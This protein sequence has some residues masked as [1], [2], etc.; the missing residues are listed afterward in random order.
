MRL[1]RFF[2]LAVGL[3]VA[4]ATADAFAIGQATGRVTG[5]V[6]EGQS[7]APIPGAVVTVSGGSGV[8]MVVQTNE[9]GTFEAT[10][11][12]P[13]TYDLVVTYEG[14]KP[15]KRRVVVNP[16]AATPVTIVWSAEA[17]Q[18]ETT[19]VEEERRL[20][21][22][23]SPQTGQIYARERTDQLPVSRAYQAISAQVP[24]ATTS[25]GNPSVKGGRLNNNRLL[26]NGLDIT[27]PVTNQATASFQMDA[28][29]SVQLTT[30]GFEAKYN[31]LGAITTVQ[32]RRGTNNFHGSAAAYWAPSELVDYDTYGSQIYDGSKPFD[33]SAIKPK[34]GRYELNVNAQGPILKDRLFFNAGI[35]YE[36]SSSVQP[37]GPP[38]NAQAPS[39]VFESI[40]I[41]GGVTFVPTPAHRIH[42]ESFFDPTHADY[43]GNTGA[44]ANST[45]PYSQTGRFAGGRR[46]TL[47]WAWQAN[48]HVATKVMIG[49]NES[50]IE[51][52]PQGLRG[53]DSSDLTNGVPYDWF[54]SNHQNQDD[55]TSWFNAGSHNVITRRR[56]QLDAA[57]TATGELGGRHEA[58]FGLQ[59][60]FTEQRSQLSYPGGT[61]GPNDTT[62]YGVFYTDR[63]GGPLDTRLCDL[64]PQL[65]P[66]ALSGNYTGTGCFRRTYSRSFAGHSSGNQF[67]TYIQDR[68]K[69]RRWLTVLPGVRWD[70]GTVR[71]T[72]SAVAVTAHGFGPRL[73]VIADVTNDQKTIA[74]VSYGRMT[75]MPTLSGV[76]SYDQARRQV[77][78]V[79]QY[80]Q[81][82]R[83]F[84]FAQTTGGSAGTRLN[85]D[86]TPA[87]ADEILVSGR[88]ELTNGVLI[89]ADY[90]YRY[91]RNQYETAEVNAIMDPTG[92]RT[93]GW[94][95]GIPQRMTLYGFNPA[96]TARYSGLDLILETR[97]PI[98][99][100]QGSY[101]LSQSMGNAGSGAF[102][103]PRFA[104]FY[105]SFQN[106]DTRHAIKTSTTFHPFPGFTIGLILNWRSGSALIKSYSANE[107]GYSVRRAPTG[108]E[109]GSYPNTGTANPGQ[110]GTYSDLRSWSTFRTP[111]LFT[112]NVMVSY[113][114]NT[115]IK[116]HVIVNLQINNL[117]A[118]ETATGINT[119]EGAPT[120][121][122]FGLAST[123]NGFRSFTLGARY[124]F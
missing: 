51:T 39:T 9:E 94:V 29:D 108:F 18:E 41:L 72:D 2:A 112:T 110:L 121:T 120:S 69:P 78:V 81:R 44:S 31:A 22:P 14:L 50:T 101:T 57:V 63:G 54:R 11:I 30:G 43:D 47:E 16:D 124:E 118:L 74:Q 5:T 38:R 60:M 79:E 80:D 20:T 1:S 105:Q 76:V 85:F 119:S 115:L 42:V 61:S 68:Y 71:A 102:D 92:T 87:S 114:F 83:R 15:F 12:P 13:G 75:E 46:G 55:G 24:G 53:I 77:G 40:Y 91:I 23:D 27:D 116:Q 10:Q 109:P 122:Q 49:G 21:N 97:L 7:K 70:V 4:L 107:S 90:T 17:A 28:L 56:A 67:A 52:G 45:T 117:L 35:R 19:V 93:V 111:D 64:D 123:R 3:G 99:E 88:R 84:Q 66:G 8:K 36:R 100:V 95:N 89:R 26:V 65:N 59:S 96:S 104:P 6:I 32:T 113:D 103:N 106:V 34:Q 58:E 48:K 82:T 25:G 62:G 33:Y 98:V 37:A 86:K 73:S